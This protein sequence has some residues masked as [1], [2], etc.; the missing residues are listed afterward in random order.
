MLRS[1]LSGAIALAFLPA[2]LV[3]AQDAPD[4]LDRVVV[5]GTRTAITVDASLAA[6]EVVDRDDIERAQAHSLPDLLRG[7]AGI[8]LVNQGGSGKL[9]TL[10]MR[11]AESTTCCSSSMACASDRRRRA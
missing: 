7:R 3:L 5:T 2:S 10:F 11:G 4:D 9:S 6:V 8:N 1:T